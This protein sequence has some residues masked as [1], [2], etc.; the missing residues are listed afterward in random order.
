MKYQEI[1]WE[2]QEVYFDEN[3]CK[4]VVRD[5]MVIMKDITAYC[6]PLVNLCYHLSLTSRNK[7][8]VSWIL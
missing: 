3:L 1:I 5:F 8:P 6:A 7:F 4:I 2:L